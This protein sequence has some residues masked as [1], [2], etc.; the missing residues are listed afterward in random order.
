MDDSALENAFD[1][2]SEGVVSEESSEQRRQVQEGMNQLECSADR[3][4]CSVK[5]RSDC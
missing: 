5:N 1:M 3:T 2:Y 4:V